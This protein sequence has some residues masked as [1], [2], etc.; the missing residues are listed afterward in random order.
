MNN[1]MDKA[2]EKLSNG[3]DK[4]SEAMDDIGE[5]F[6]PDYSTPVDQTRVRLYLDDLLLRKT[7]AVQHDGHTYRITIEEINV[8]K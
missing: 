5:A 3:M 8:G 6:K 4:I 7:C 1:W 2:M